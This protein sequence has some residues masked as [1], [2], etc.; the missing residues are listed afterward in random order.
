MS[1]L[2]SFL[3]QDAA[4]QAGQ[5]TEKAVGQAEKQ[6]GDLA[7][8]RAMAMQRLQNPA[9]YDYASAFRPQANPLFDQAQASGA[10]ALSSLDSSPDYYAQA[11]SKLG[12]LNAIEDAQLQNTYRA[13]GQKNA[14]LGRIGSAQVNTEN[15]K[16]LADSLLMRDAAKRSFLSDAL[17]QDYANRFRKIGVASDVAGQQFGFGQAGVANRA[18]QLA[19]E[20]A[21]RGQD[22]GQM[23]GLAGF[24]SSY[25]PEG[26][27]GRA[28]D[29]YNQE[30]AAKMQTVASL[31][32]SAARAFGSSGA[33]SAGAG[34]AGGR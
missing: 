9:T 33:G 1:W 32:G 28:A 18:A 27:Y 25:S 20:S 17:N 11:A 19:A 7:P 31:L 23:M 4:K 13:I 8:Y 5:Y 22:F 34:A 21:A 26:A 12:D 24:G 16:A 29:A 2:S 10:R 15:S 3:G 6:Y 30:A 14:A